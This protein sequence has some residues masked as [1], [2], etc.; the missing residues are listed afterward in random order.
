MKN[1]PL[2]WL[3]LHVLIESL[4]RDFALF[5]IENISIV[6]IPFKQS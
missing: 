6:T 5:I 1:M 2:Y 3:I 4:I